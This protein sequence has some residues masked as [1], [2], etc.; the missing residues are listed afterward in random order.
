MTFSLNNRLVLQPYVR[1][2]LRAQVKNG[3][4][5]PGQRDGLKGLSVLVGTVLMDGRHVPA[6]SIAY[7]REEAL[8][9]QPWASKFLSCDFLKTQFMLVDLHHIEVIVTPEE[10]A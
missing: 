2:G 10:A 4:A 9:T 6:G 3:I 8:H 5:T 1:D 7:I